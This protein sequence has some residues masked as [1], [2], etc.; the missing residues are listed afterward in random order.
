M[1]D[2][3]KLIAEAIDRAN[4]LLRH[5]FELHETGQPI[6]L[7]KLIEDSHEL[8][9]P[10]AVEIKRRFDIYVT[11]RRM[12]FSIEDASRAV[13]DEDRLFREGSRLHSDRTKCN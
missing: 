1:P 12:G 8:A 6:P 4:F 10:F 11:H 13:L 9:K 2:H 5:C 7:D 3:S